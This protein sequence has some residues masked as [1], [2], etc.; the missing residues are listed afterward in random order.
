[1]FILS[2]QVIVSRTWFKL[3]P[4][5]AKCRPFLF[6]YQMLSAPVLSK[7][8]DRVRYQLFIN[9][10]KSLS[11]E[12]LKNSNFV[13]ESDGEIKIA[14]ETTMKC[15][16]EPVHLSLTVAIVIIM[17]ATTLVLTCQHY[18]SLSAQW[19][20]CLKAWVPVSNGERW[21]AIH[22]ALLLGFAAV[23]GIVIGMGLEYLLRVPLVDLLPPPLQVM[24]INLRW[25][26][27]PQSLIAVPALGIPVGHLL[28]VNAASVM[29]NTQKQNR[30]RWNIALCLCPYHAC[31]IGK[32]SWFGWYL[33]E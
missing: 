27:W 1:M 7:S 2:Y 6:T 17:A 12:Q 20:Q 3:Q 26:R 19:S 28:N 16:K 23:S 22:P 18:V 9:A 5:S 29:Q 31:F 25:W 4:I 21:L 32:T 33:Q 8:A 30:M 14:A 10:E 15:L 13:P 11:L 24:V